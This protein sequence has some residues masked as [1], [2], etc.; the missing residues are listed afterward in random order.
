LL[1]RFRP[2]RS[3]RDNR[4]DFA[5]DKFLGERAEALRLFGRKAVDQFDILAFN[6]RALGKHHGKLLP[7]AFW[8]AQRETFGDNPRR[9]Y[10][11]A[12]VYPQRIRAIAD[13][14]AY[15]TRELERGRDGWTRYRDKGGPHD[16]QRKRTLDSYITFFER[17]IEWFKKRW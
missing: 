5:C 14:P 16:A 17:Q 10:V 7:H 2:Q 3:D 6:V 13:V 11:M 4:V 12:G 15:I 1:G 9:P 8:S